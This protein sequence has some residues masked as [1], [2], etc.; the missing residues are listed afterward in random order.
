MEWVNMTPGGKHTEKIG[1]PRPYGSQD[2]HRKLCLPYPL[3]GGSIQQGGL[4]IKTKND[5]SMLSI[6]GYMPTKFRLP[7]SFSVP[8]ILDGNLDMRKIKTNK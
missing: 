2:I 3:F 4:Q 1:H 5:G 8:G 7:Q 6:W